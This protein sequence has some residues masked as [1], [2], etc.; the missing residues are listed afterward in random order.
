MEILGEMHDLPVQ[1][2]ANRLNGLFTL[3]YVLN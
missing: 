3:S 1:K 2:H